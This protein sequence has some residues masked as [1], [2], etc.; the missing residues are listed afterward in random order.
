M[1]ASG[2]AVRKIMLAAHDLGMT[3]INKKTGRAEYAF[4]NIQLFDSAYFGDIGWKNGTEGDARDEDAKE[5]Y[6]SLMTLTLRKPDTK[7]YQDFA[8][9]VKQR[10]LEDYGFDYDKEGEDVNSFVGAF[11]DAVILYALALNET[12]EEGGTPRDGHTITHK[13][14][15]RTFE[16]ISGDVRIDDNGD[17]DADYS[18]LE[19]TDIENGTFS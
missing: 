11:H 16:G 9:E 15:N 5:A 4:F 7:E 1:C 14:W 12:L 13:M 17:R 18:L 2:A 6:R 8:R 3:K 10:A 19:M